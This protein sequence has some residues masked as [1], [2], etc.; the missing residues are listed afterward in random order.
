MVRA[1]NQVYHK[2]CF[3][4]SACGKLLP[5]TQYYEYKKKPCCKK[6][7][8]LQTAQDVVVESR[9][10][11]LVSYAPPPETP[12][13]TAEPQ[14]QTR[15][16]LTRRI[17]LGS[18]NAVKC[19]ICE[20]SVFAN[21]LVSTLGKT[22]HQNC[23]RC[24]G[25]NRV[26]L[27]TQ[28]WEHKKRPCCKKC[29]EQFNAQETI[30]E[31]RKLAAIGL[32]Q[33]APSPPPQQ[34]SP[35]TPP[36][37]TEH[38]S[39]QPQQPQQPQQAPAV[40]VRRSFGGGV[41]RCCVCD[42]AVFSNELVSALGRT[43]HQNCFRCVG[44]SRVLLATQH[45][46]HKKRPC[47]KK[48]CEQFNAEDTVEE[49]RKPVTYTPAA[50]A[51][52]NTE[53]TT[54]EQQQPKEAPAP[55]HERK[56]SFGGALVHCCVCET[57]V[58]A[59][60]RVDALGKT[61]HQ[62]CFRC[63]GCNRVL[64]ATQHW[65]HNKRPCCKKCCEQFNAQDVVEEARKQATVVFIPAVSSPQPQQPA[66]PDQS[67]SPSS[68]PGEPQEGDKPLK[69]SFGGGG[70]KCCVCDTSVFSN[71]L[72][73]ALGRT[74]HKRCFRCVGCSRTLLPTQHWEHK[75]RP[76]CKKCW[77]QFNAQD[78]VE[79]A[80]KQAAVAYTPLVLNNC[81]VEEEDDVTDS[82]DEVLE[83]GTGSEQPTDSG[84]TTAAPLSKKFGGAADRCCVCEKPIFANELAR[85]LNQSY[86]RG[87][88]KCFNCAR[89]LLPTQF[90][91]HNKRPCCKKC[92]DQLAARDAL[93]LA[94]LTPTPTASPALEE[95]QGEDGQPR[96]R[97]NTFGGGAVACA[98]CGKSVFLNEQVRVL[99]QVYHRACLVCLD[100]G[101]QLS[102]SKH[103]EHHK[104]PY[105][106]RCWESLVAAEILEEARTA[107]PSLQTTGIATKSQQQQTVT[108]AEAPKDDAVEAEQQARQRAL[109]DA[110]AA[111]SPYSRSR[112][113]SPSPCRSTS[114]SSDS[115]NEPQFGARLILPTV[116]RPR[117]PKGRA[118]RSR[119]LRP[120]SP[121]AEA[122]AGA[123]NPD[124]L[125]TG[126][127]GENWW[128]AFEEAKAKAEQQ[129]VKEQ[130]ERREAEHAREVEREALRA[131]ARERREVEEAML[132]QEREKT[133]QATARLRE[134][135][136]R[137]NEEL[138]KATITRHVD[139]DFRLRLIK[140][141]GRRKIQVNEVPPNSPL[142][143]GASFILDTGGH[144]YVFHGPEANKIEVARAV[145]VAH[146]L[147]HKE[148]TLLTRL[149]L[150]SKLEL[151]E[152]DPLWGAL[153][154]FRQ[155]DPTFEDSIEYE[156]RV[157]S[158]YLLLRCE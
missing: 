113:L 144:V 58:F 148:H 37:P 12:S 14:G 45:W 103:W 120:R 126:G 30:E 13:E 122:D 54:Q 137:A 10:T 117:P 136:R 128:V 96:G 43:Y 70:V 77:E 40:T 119:Q 124:P 46:E 79:D 60:E 48:C 141:K 64:L 11:A 15:S 114:P 156:N 150:Y 72:V 132:V 41:V 130:Q 74:Y 29:Y 65:E 93:L 42:K 16:P 138:Y 69:R 27:A 26:L 121:L 134:E 67:G 158:S 135:Q 147:K 92:R 85:V 22:Y 47:C 94:T 100:C 63:V 129:W 62:N 108:G 151:D 88:L 78:V 131:K 84:A 4:C 31:A 155:F 44:C 7:R 68:L 76:C 105:C 107:A 8:E 149:S 110:S 154:G 90:C 25:C 51:S 133:E 102:V 142:Y 111:S 71:E 34:P 57:S 139:L 53:T 82:E 95:Q 99:G 145:D 36:T 73:S 39:E 101:K 2:D 32:T 91:E 109:T 9:G 56:R 153:G 55:T 33:P 115:D 98:T 17:T 143:A 35:A 21:E 1:L 123:T 66:S 87:C 140:V 24:I 118:Q 28:H 97:R 61:Y 86:H 106:H 125:E 49:A 18:S 75:K 38:S 104:K 83:E 81:P 89:Q 157:E 5:P 116:S 50:S 23:F 19:C 112:S 59:N 152:S 3:K 146:K 80:R 20:K 6:C 52:A 127:S